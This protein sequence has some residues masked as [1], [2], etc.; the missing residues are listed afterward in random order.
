[1]SWAENKEAVEFFNSRADQEA[2]N[3]A[4]RNY[5]INSDIGAESVEITDQE[6]H[7][8]I[9]NLRYALEKDDSISIKRNVDCFTEY[10]NQDHQDDFPVASFLINQGIYEDIEKCFSLDNI[11]IINSILHFMVAI[12]YATPENQDQVFEH[13]IIPSIFQLL[14]TWDTYEDLDIKSILSFFTNFII[15]FQESANFI[16]ETEFLK[17]LPDLL[18]N[19]NLIVVYHTVLLIESLSQDY[20]DYYGLIELSSIILSLKEILNIIK[21]ESNDTIIIKIISSILDI[22]L[23]MSNDTPKSNFFI[24]IG[25]ANFI[26]EKYSTSNVAYQISM[27]QILRSIIEHSDKN[28]NFYNFI[29]LMTPEFFSSCLKTPFYKITISAIH[30]IYNLFDFSLDQAEQIVSTNDICFIII[31]LMDRTTCK[32]QESC[33]KLFLSIFEKSQYNDTKIKFVNNK[34]IRNIISY[35]DEIDDEMLKKRIT[36]SLHILASTFTTNE[37]IKALVL[38]LYDDELLSEYTDPRPLFD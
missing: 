2:E 33:I 30:I 11:I 23:F 13:N 24:S 9:S 12:T 36:N 38:P 20:N 21:L 5:H 15:N 27:I 16:K 6:Y 17:L 18:K 26:I 31:D 10:L 1:M 29:Y 28:D 8:I 19:D 22:Y 3:R 4:L 34:V 32:I 37:I 25:I 14:K 7:I 35:A